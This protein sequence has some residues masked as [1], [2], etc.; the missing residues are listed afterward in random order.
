MAHLH[1]NNYRNT[2]FWEGIGSKIKTGA[3]VAGAIKGIWDVG[4]TIYTGIRAAAPVVGAIAA[5][6]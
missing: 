2:G 3:E 6:L 4:K 5:A 1:N